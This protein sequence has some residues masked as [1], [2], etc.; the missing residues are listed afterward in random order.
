MRHVSVMSGHPIFTGFHGLT[1]CQWDP[2][3]RGVTLSAYPMKY[4]VMVLRS[5]FFSYGL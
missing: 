2:R 3:D 5:S 4:P 1:C